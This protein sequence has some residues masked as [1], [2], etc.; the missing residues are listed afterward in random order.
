MI[1]I[2]LVMQNRGI[3]NSKSCKANHKSS[4][5]T[6]YEMGIS[7][8]GAGPIKQTRKYTMNKY[9]I[10]ATN[11]VIKWV[12]ARTLRTNTIVPTTKKLYECILTMFRCP[13]IIV[14]DQG[15]HFINDVIKCLTNHFLMKHMN[16]ITYYPQ[17]NG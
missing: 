1:T 4:R 14:I 17:G 6:V 16:F 2:N 12:E 10:D 13:L 15:V 7:F 5:G 3:G 11:Y 9:I 8:C